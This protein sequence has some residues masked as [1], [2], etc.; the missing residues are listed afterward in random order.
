MAVG[1]GFKGELAIRRGEPKQGVESLL[2]CL[3]ELHPVR[4]EPLTTTF[5]VALVQ[6]LAEIGRLAES[7]TLIDETIRLVTANGDL[8]YMPELLRVKGGLLRSMSQPLAANAEVH[9]CSR[10]SG[11]VVRARDPGSCA[12]RSI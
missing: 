7:I 10:S 12:Q 6:G 2:G 3:D 4:Y 9:S 1:R 11:A 8:F 5:N